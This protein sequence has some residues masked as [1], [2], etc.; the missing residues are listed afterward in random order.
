[1]S[2]AEFST[3]ET[4]GA[5]FQVKAFSGTLCCSVSFQSASGKDDK[6][7]HKSSH[8]IYMMY[9]AWSLTEEYL[10]LLLAVFK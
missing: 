1:M 5:Y 2:P 8:K 3:E 10:T 9:L 4:A 7:N 6:G